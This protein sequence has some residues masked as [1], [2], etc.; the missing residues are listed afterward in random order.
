MTYNLL[1]ALLGQ[2][3]KI[4]AIPQG[5]IGDRKYCIFRVHHAIFSSSSI[6]VQIS[7]P[8]FFK[9]TALRC[10]LAF[11]WAKC[12]LTRKKLKPLKKNDMN[13]VKI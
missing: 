5:I 13:D 6:K 2:S 7:P 9:K 8:N 3:C 10:V 11:C 4:I 1:N 12:H